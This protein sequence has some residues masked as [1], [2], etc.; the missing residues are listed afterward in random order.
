MGS[1]QVPAVDGEGIL[2]LD[3]LTSAPQMTQAGC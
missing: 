3:E 1:A 2:F